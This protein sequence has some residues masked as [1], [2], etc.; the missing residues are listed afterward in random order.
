M[1]PSRAATIRNRVLDDTRHRRR[2]HALFARQASAGIVSALQFGLYADIGLVAFAL[3]MTLFLPRTATTRSASAPAPAEVGS[4]EFS[5]F[6]GAIETR[7]SPGRIDF[8]H[9]QFGTGD[10]S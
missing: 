6:D 5:M 10:A 7:S 9:G 4:E 8:A 2:R 1:P 3:I